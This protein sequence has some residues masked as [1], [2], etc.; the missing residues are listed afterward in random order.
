MI[1][2]LINLLVLAIV[3]SLAYWILG[4]LPVPPPV[5]QII[6]VAIAVIACIFVIYALLGIAGSGSLAIR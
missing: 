5:K 1:T 6:T 2:L 4:L 3:C